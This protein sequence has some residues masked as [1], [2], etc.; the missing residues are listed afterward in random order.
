MNKLAALTF[1]AVLFV[2]AAWAGSAADSITAVDPYVRAVP[3]GQSNTAAFMVLQNSDAIPHAVVKADNPAS[4][5]TEL[6]SHVN[7]D[8]VMEMRP[9]KQ[10]DIPAKGEAKLQPGGLHIMLIDLKQPPKAGDTV[11]V[12]LTFE[13]GSTKQVAAQVRHPGGMMMMG[14]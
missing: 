12:T 6:H 11:A 3:P 10:I 2:P 5:F 14:H 4:K 9:V 13:D 1:A 7:K 8:G